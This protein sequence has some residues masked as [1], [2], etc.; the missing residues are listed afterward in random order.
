[1]SLRHLPLCVLLAVHSP[2]AAA[3]YV[4]LR[5]VYTGNFISQGFDQNSGVVVD[6]NADSLLL[7]PGDAVTLRYLSAAPVQIGDRLISYAAAHPLA[8][9]RSHRLMGYLTEVAG[10]LEV[11]QVAGPYAEATLVSAVAEVELGQ[12][13]VAMRQPLYVDVPTHAPAVALQGEVMAVAHKLLMGSEQHLIYLDRGAQAGLAV[14]DRLQ[15]AGR[16]DT[17]RSPAPIDVRAMP[18][19]E[20]VVVATQPHTATALVVDALWEVAVGNPFVAVPQGS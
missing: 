20:V 10:L 4:T 6:A 19:A 7:K 17:I 2:A 18:M 8:H 16:R 14:G 5:H 11:T 12:R 3:D 1:M 9:P 15:V 13:V